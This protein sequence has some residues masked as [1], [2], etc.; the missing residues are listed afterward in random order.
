[1]QRTLGLG[2]ALWIAVGAIAVA[3]TIH[4]RDGITLPSPPAVDA[5]PVAD[6]YFGTKIVDSYRWLEDPKST[7]TRA[8]IDAENAYTTRYL[9]QAHIRSQVQDDLEA[10][11]NVSEPRSRPFTF[12]SMVIAPTRLNITSGITSFISSFAPL[13]SE[14]LTGRSVT[15]KFF[16]VQRQD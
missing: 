16:A 10:L 6:D 4:G 2:L 15:V 14:P 9:K 12:A 11:E 1:M 8:F 3:Q 5:V 7:E 13:V